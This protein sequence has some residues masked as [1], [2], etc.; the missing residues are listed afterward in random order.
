MGAPIGNQNA[1]KAKRWQDAL[2]KALARFATPDGVIQ[3]GQA[4]DK[5]AELVVM[6]A[7]AGD[8]DAI[9]EIGNRLD[10]KPAQAIIG[11]SDSDPV[12][13]VGKIELVSLGAGCAS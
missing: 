1:R 6:Q 7:L 12:Q 4:L 13:V 11:D 8:K 9:Q 2:T 3:A 5:I 10:G